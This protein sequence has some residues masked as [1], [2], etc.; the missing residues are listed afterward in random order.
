MQ[1]PITRP[2]TTTSFS[3]SDAPMRTRLPPNVTRELNRHGRRVCY[4]RV[5]KGPRVRLP[6]YGTPE[7][8]PAYQAALRGDPVPKP[9]RA[10]DSVPGTVAWVIAAYKQS[11]HWRGLDDLTRR[12]RDAAFRQLVEKQGTTQVRRVTEA[13]I[14]AA[15][16][17]RTTGKGHPA[18][19]WLKAIKPLFAFA[20]ERG[21]IDTDP[22]RGV[23][24]VRPLK[25][26]R[27]MWQI[28][29]VMA[30]E[31]RHPLGTMANLA[32]RILLFTGFRIS[33]AVQLGR[34]HLRGG[35]IRF[36][37]GKTAQSSGVLVTFT[38]LPPLIEAITA[39]E[40]GDLAFLVT[41]KGTPFASGASFGNWFARRC[42]EAGVPGSAHGLRKLGPT[43]AAQAGAS[44]HELM[45]MWG[46]TTLA[47]AELYTRAANRVLLGGTASS[48]LM[49]GYLDMVQ[50]A[51]NIP[52]TSDAGAGITEKAE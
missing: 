20:K 14:Q 9:G 18:N 47:Q 8:E 42:R 32:L 7:F 15:R 41:E 22:A 36:R 46:W 37:P 52:R 10:P 21:F 39:T 35:T 4:Y 50:A 6:D 11:L 44:A 28:E 38:A 26:G 13:A 51:N 48:K 2:L 3:T 19:N 16:D 31:A 23:D 34:Q 17:K 12:R 5:G 33:D 1:P 40:T 25:G 29:D 49:T 24:Y 43:L 27:I 45:A 30:F